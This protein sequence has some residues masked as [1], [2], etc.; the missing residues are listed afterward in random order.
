[1][2]MPNRSLTLLQ[3]TL[4]AGL[5]VVG[6]GR[7]GEPVEEAESRRDPALEAFWANFRAA[8]SA[9]GAGDLE[10]A[11]GLYEQALAADPDHGDTLY[12]LGHF[13]YARGETVAA[14]EHFERLAE[15]EPAGLR[16]WQQ[17]SLARGQSRSGWVGDLGGAEAAASRALD[18]VRA[19]SLN[20]ELLARWAGYRGESSIAREHIATALGHNQRS[21][22][23]RLLEEWLDGP[24]AVNSAVRTSA[25]QRAERHAAYPVDLNADGAADLTLYDVGGASPVIVAE[26]GGQ[27]HLLPSASRVAA[28]EEGPESAASG[29]FPVP[30][31]AALIAGP[32]GERIVLVGGG[33]RGTR[34]YEVEGGLYREADAGVLP[35]PVGEPLVASAD[36]DGDGTDDLVLANIRL[37]ADSQS[38]GARVFRGRLDGSFQDAGV[39]IPGRLVQV[40]VADVDGDGDPDLIVGRPGQ[41]VAA[42]EEAGDHAPPVAAAATVAVSILTNDGGRLASTSIEAPVLEG[43]VRD[44]VVADLDGDGRVDLLFAMGSWSPERKVADALWLGTDAGFVDASDRL[45]APSSGSTF[46]AWAATDGLVLVRGGAVPADSQTTVLLQIR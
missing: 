3:A 10:R 4:V 21:E 18:V 26:T 37:D 41:T 25:I 45:G 44:I 36:F 19:E 38:L 16:S 15:V 6:C 42:T 17:L 9:R 33:H 12:Y 39:D 34:L 20:Y 27:R 29:P 35:T 28:W 5:L 23:A 24:A 32:Y 43:E 40:A 2:L 31:H 22:A 46:R 8:S 7:A 1:M 30:S 13:R 14:L 11:A